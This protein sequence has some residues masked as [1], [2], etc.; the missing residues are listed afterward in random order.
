MTTDTRTGLQDV[1]TR[2]HVTNLDNLIDINVVMTTELNQLVGKTMLTVRKVY[3]TTL[4]I[5]AVLISVTTIFHR[6]KDS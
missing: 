1:N 3:S 5:S 4:L 2:V 6:Q